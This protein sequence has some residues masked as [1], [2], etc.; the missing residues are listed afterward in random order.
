MSLFINQ[1]ILTILGHLS[2]NHLNEQELLHILGDENSTRVLEKLVRDEM[3]QVNNGIYSVTR[4]GL[5]NARNLFD[6]P[7]KPNSKGMKRR[8][9]IQI[10]IL[11]LLKEE[12]R[13]GY[14]VMKL[15]EER[16]NGFYTPSAGTV[17]PALQ[18]LHDKG[19]ITVV[20]QGDKKVY[21]LHSDGLLFLAEAVQGEEDVFWED[22]RIRLMWKQSKQAGLVREEMDKFM[23]EYHI[24]MRSIMQKS[25]HAE[26]FI[27]ILK[28]A[29]EQVINWSDQQER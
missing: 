23:L 10:A 14:Q 18:D 26:E 8:G 21:T 13:H 24:A 9:L 7:S 27:S 19:L 17:Y 6:R 4:K 29:R 20:E 1:D 16:S 5:K 3:I 12:P 2:R 28:N 22:W 25:E 11:K 15:L